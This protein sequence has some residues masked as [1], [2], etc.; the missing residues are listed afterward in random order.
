MLQISTLRQGTGKVLSWPLHKFLDKLYRVYVHYTLMEQGGVTV[1][2]DPLSGVPA[3][4]QIVDSLRILLVERKLAPGSALPSVRRLAMELGVHFNTVAEAYRE[5]A[6]EGWVDLQHGRG[7]VVLAR[8]VR[9]TAP[10][11]WLEEFRNRLRGLV[12]QVRSEGASADELAAE[13]KAM[14]KAVKMS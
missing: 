5:L 9:T 6:A 8:P 14:A 12:A 2:F 7:A 10:E 11:S 13:L 3:V 4:R 1:R